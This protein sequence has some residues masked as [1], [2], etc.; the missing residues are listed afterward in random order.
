[1]LLLFACQVSQHKL[2][3]LRLIPLRWLLRMALRGLRFYWCFHCRK[4][5]EHTCWCVRKRER[6]QA[7]ACACLSRCVP[8]LS[9]SR[10]KQ[11]NSN[12]RKHSLKSSGEES[13]ITNTH[14]YTMLLFFSLPCPPPT[15]WAADNLALNTPYWQL[16]LFQ[17]ILFYLGHVS[18]LILLCS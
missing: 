17:T 2:R 5:F 6:M 11:I 12:R 15:T 7:W 16:F 3:R 4:T 1:M 18:V 14:K 13:P 9:L 8:V 10:L